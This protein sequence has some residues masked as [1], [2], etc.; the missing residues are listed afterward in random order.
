MCG[1]FA[2]RLWQV[3][4]RRIMQSTSLN[5]GSRASI[6][7]AHMLMPQLVLYQQLHSTSCRWHSWLNV[8]TQG[9]EP[10]AASF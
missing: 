1:G 6:K 10:A 4:V 3:W 9:Q 8:C 5:T 2:K 7:Q